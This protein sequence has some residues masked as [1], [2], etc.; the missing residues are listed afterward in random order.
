MTTAMADSSIDPASLA[1]GRRRL[2]AI[3]LI[4]ALADW[5]LFADTP[6]V[7]VALFFMGHCGMV[8]LAN[9]ATV[10]R[11]RLLVAGGA[12]TG[13]DILVS[14]KVAA[15]GSWRRRWLAQVTQVCPDPIVANGFLR[16]AKP[17][18][19]GTD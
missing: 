14:G 8:L 11:R 19:T 1:L 15:P 17:D 13:F 6:G 9:P 18:P 3:L 2:A 7:S 16:L 10:P 4:T 5:L 12:V